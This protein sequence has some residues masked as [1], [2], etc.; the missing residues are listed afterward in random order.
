MATT[1]VSISDLE[2]LSKTYP[3]MEALFKSGG[4]RAVSARAAPENKPRVSKAQ[5]RIVKGLRV[6]R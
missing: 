6:E 1:S 2:D 4:A 3:Y 5:M